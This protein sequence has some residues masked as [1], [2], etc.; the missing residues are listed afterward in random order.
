VLDRYIISLLVDPIKK[1]LGLTDV[2]FGIRHLLAGCHARRRIRDDDGYV[3]RNVLILIAHPAGSSRCSK[4]PRAGSS[5]R[6]S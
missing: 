5:T 1:D 2:Q 3:S 6:C 4:C